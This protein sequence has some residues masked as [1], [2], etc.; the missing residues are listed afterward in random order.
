MITG[1][2]RGIGAACAVALARDGYSV[3]IGYNNSVEEAARVAEATGGAAIRADVADEAAVMEMFGGIGRVDALVC[4][5]GVSHYGLFTDIT[6][7]E[8]RRVFDVNVGGVINCCRAAIPRMI[9]E[10]RGRIVLI[11]SIW[12]SCGA[13]CEA[14]YS[15]SK[16]AVIG[17]TKAL[18]KELG[19]SGILVNCVAPGVIET[20]MLST[21]TEEMRAALRADTPLGRTGTPEDVAG[22]VRFL[23]SEAASF[24]TGQVISPNGGILI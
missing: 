3:Y 9:G 23:T 5:A 20:D 1:G 6:D 4:C 11:S 18:A 10:K 19:P 7:A 24:I 15:A 12:G 22:V 16:A 14:V 8:W 13:S 21:L 17:L 2:S